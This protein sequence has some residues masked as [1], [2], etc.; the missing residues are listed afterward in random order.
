MTSSQTLPSEEKPTSCT[1][2]GCDHHFPQD[3][4]YGWSIALP[5]SGRVCL[6]H[7]HRFQRY[8]SNAR[9]KRSYTVDGALQSLWTAKEL[10]DD[11][12]R[13]CAFGDDLELL[14]TETVHLQY[15]RSNM[16]FERTPGSAIWRISVND[17]HNR[18]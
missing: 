5:G 4:Q 15:K 17:T 12:R 14:P 13:Q 7:H 16:M 11:A 8:T 9:K 6:M 18:I 1:V 10:Q 3:Q 2:R